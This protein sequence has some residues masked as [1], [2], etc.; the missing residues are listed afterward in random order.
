M[1]LK[2][3][4]WGETSTLAGDTMTDPKQEKPIIEYP[5]EWG[6]KVIGT[7]EQVVRNAVKECLDAALYRETGDREFELGLSRASKGGKYLSLSLT[8]VVMTEEE[9]DGIFRAMT[10]HPDI[11]MVM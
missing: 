5:V 1:E 8:L 3:P 7:D 2:G 11:L 4:F 9:R 6:Y 10:G